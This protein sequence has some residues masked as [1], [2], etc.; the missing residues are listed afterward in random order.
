MKNRIEVAVAMLK[1]DGVIFVQCDDNEYPY[2]KVLMDEVDGVKY[3]LTYYVQ[4]R[5]AQKTLAEN[6]N[7]QK[8]IEHVLCYYETKF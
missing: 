8:L 7:Y 2:L 4:V 5:Y 6:S 1:D 3:E